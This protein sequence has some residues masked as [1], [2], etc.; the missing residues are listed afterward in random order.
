M[1]IAVF[2]VATSIMLFLRSNT[3]IGSQLI[4]GT[5]GA[6][7]LVQTRSVL[8]NGSLA[9]ADTPFIF[10]LEGA[11]AWIINLFANNASASTTIAVKA[12][13]SVL[14]SLIGLPI[15]LLL[16]RKKGYQNAALGCIVIILFITLHIYQ[17][18]LVSDLQKNAL[19]NVLFLSS[20]STFIIATTEKNN[21]FYVIS[22]ILF[23]LTALTHIG[24]FAVG[25]IFIMVY[26]L[27][28]ALLDLK[29]KPKNLLYL[30]VSIVSVVA[31]A[32]VLIMFGKTGTLTQIVNL[33]VKILSNSWISNVFKSLSV[34]GAKVPLLEIVVLVTN[35]L[36]VLFSILNLAKTWK[37]RDISSKSTI[38]SLIVT[39]LVLSSPLIGMDYA[40]RFFLL[41]FMPISMLMM[42]V[43]VI[44]NSNQKSNNSI[45]ITASIV[46]LISLVSVI[47][48]KPIPAISEAEYRDLSS[49][50]TACGDKHDIVVTK[51]GFEWWCSWVTKMPVIQQYQVEP[52]LW[53]EYDNVVY[54]RS[55]VKESGNESRMQE[56]QE[57]TI[58]EGSIEIYKSNYLEAFRVTIPQ[59]DIKFGMPAAKGM[60]AHR[61][62][63]ALKLLTR[64]G[65]VT[66]FID[67]KTEIS[68]KSFT[69]PGNAIEVWGENRFFV[70]DIHA[71]KIS[72]D[73][74]PMKPPEKPMHP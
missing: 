54:L 57:V 42:V 47:Q 1:L 72:L 26:Y 10:W 35:H 36:I 74:H 16:I 64:N 53:L 21:S 73:P 9:F 11:L 46:V 31:L 30:A 60:V 12:I 25:F 65:E 19:G 20:L 39:S 24:C 29:Q 59:N 49:F 6:Y 17:Y 18:M 61:S 66:V 50:K 52:D 7:Y 56:F 22:L 13:D 41:S 32:V 68:D 5:N 23:V 2:L 62:E 71:T 8:Q 3:N 38:I 34:P 70:T 43:F 44:D 58:P 37:T 48:F 55:I 63:N 45:I 28:L 67:G 40:A 33:P 15:L 14:P 69:Q 51:H 4:P 27:L